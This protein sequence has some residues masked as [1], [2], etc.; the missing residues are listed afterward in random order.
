MIIRVLFGSRRLS[1]IHC[2]LAY[3]SHSEANQQMNNLSKLG[4]F[5]VTRPLRVG[6]SAITRAQALAPGVKFTSH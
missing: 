4:G 1:G 2:T 5:V 6:S 3:H